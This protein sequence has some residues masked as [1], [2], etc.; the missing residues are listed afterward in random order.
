[1]ISFFFSNQKMVFLM[2]KLKVFFYSFSI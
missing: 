2:L 1:M